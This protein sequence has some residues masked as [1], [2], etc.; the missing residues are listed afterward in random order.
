MLKQEEEQVLKNL[1]LKSK[2]KKKRKK[3]PHM[4]DSGYGKDSSVIRLKIN[5]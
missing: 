1:R 5:G 3:G 2:R 4:A